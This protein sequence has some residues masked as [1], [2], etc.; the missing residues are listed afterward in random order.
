MTP[1]IALRPVQDEDYEI[2]AELEKSAFESSKMFQLLASRVK[3]EDLRQW[4]WHDGAKADVASGGGKVLVVENPDS[5][6]VMGVAWFTTYTPKNQPR[7]PAVYP[8][9]YN[10]VEAEK[11][12]IPRVAWLRNVVETYGKCVRKFA[13]GVEFPA[14]LS[15]YIHSTMPVDVQEIFIAKAY[16]G[17]GIGKQLMTVI[18]EGARDSGCN[19]TLTAGPGTS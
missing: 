3:P 4:I 13:S 12:I 6:E 8:Q 14:R 7:V 5:K 17:L 19:I 9:G 11:I 15:T 10:V 1:P 18:I 2:I 16:H